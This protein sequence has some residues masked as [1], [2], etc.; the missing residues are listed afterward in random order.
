M[1]KV[2]NKDCSK[3]SSLNTKIDSKG[4]PWGYDCLKYGDSVLQ[5]DFSDTKVF[6]IFKNT[7]EEKVSDRV[8]NRKASM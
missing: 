8:F 5:E 1:I 7:K 6:S 3:C 2:C 4:Y